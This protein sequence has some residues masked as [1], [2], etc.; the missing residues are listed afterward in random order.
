MWIAKQGG[1]LR[2]PEHAVLELALFPLGQRLLRSKG[3]D[4]IE[5][6]SPLISHSRDRSGKVGAVTKG[7]QLLRALLEHDRR[8][9]GADEAQGA[10]VSRFHSFSVPGEDLLVVGLPLRHPNRLGKGE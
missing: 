6:P 4:V 9:A 3:L 5:Q 8:G 10:R 7:Q 2:A 1:H